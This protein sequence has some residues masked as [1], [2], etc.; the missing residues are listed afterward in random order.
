L[1]PI[2]P[3]YNPDGSYNDDGPYAN[4]ISIANQNINEAYNWSNFGNIY[5]NYN[6]FKNF[7]YKIKLGIDYVNLRE[8]TYDPPTTRQGAKYQGYG[9]EATF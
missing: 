5:A 8:H 9:E 6:L 7:S 2:Y 1:T 4:P 3:V